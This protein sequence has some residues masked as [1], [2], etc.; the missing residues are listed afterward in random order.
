MTL[1]H[2][3]PAF[4]QPEL[5]KTCGEHYVFKQGRCF[6][7]YHAEEQEHADQQR[8]ERLIEKH[9]GREK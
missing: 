9:F 1:D 5:C 4:K 7:C 6:E 8:K 2:S 3:D